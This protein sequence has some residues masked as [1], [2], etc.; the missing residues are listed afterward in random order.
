MLAASPFRTAATIFLI[1]LLAVAL[2]RGAPFLVTSM[3]ALANGP[4][5]GDQCVKIV[6]APID[7]IEV[8]MRRVR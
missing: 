6:S 8:L 5:R 7:T 2:V 1:G 3:V 4:V